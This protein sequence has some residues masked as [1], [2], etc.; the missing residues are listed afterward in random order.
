MTYTNPNHSQKQAHPST[1]FYRNFF[2]FAAPALG[3]LLLSPCAK[4]AGKDAQA[5]ERTV[6]VCMTERPDD[7]TVQAKMGASRIFRHIGVTVAWHNDARF[8]QAHPDQ[9][10][11][12][13]YSHHT[14]KELRPGA[15]ATALP[16][17]GIHIE[18]FYD[19]ILDVQ[20]AVRPADHLG[21]VLAHEI[22]HV[23]QGT[24]RHS[25]S[26]LMKA[27]WDRPELA[28]MKDSHYLSFTDLDA[29]LIYAGLA[30]RDAAASTVTAA[31][32]VE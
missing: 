22:T 3:L 14:P 4:L 16:F 20:A 2:R 15:L 24:A 8:C 30:A 7:V 13:S 5:A 25:D 12:I 29:Q 18:I 11:V 10:I 32:R 23:L 26:G 21:H 9:A 28:Q 31:N 27:H 19:R 1:A 17:E 6:T